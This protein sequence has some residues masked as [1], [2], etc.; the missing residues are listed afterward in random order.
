MTSQQPLAQRMGMVPAAEPHAEA[1]IGVDAIA[2]VLW[3][4]KWVLITTLAAFL[5]FGT[6]Y[7][8]VAQPIYVADALV[9]VE[10]DESSSLSS[11]ISSEMAKI[12]GV[13]SEA[14]VDAE[15]Q[16][17]KSRLV[18]GQVIDNRKMELKAEPSYFPIFGRALARRGWTG[19]SAPKV[20]E[21][22]DLVV[23]KSLLGV[24]FIVTK[25]EN[26]FSLREDGS[27]DVILQGKVGQRAV[28]SVPQ[29]EIQ[30]F[31]SVLE[32]KPGSKFEVKRVPWL[33]VISTLQQQ[34]QVTEKGSD[35]G[36]LSVTAEATDP[37]AAR[38]V[39]NQIVTI[40]QRQNVERKS[41]EAENQLKFVEEQ[42][43][44]VRK[45]LAVAE[46]A[47]N[48]FRLKNGSVDLTKETE[49]ALSS[50]VDLESKR[51]DLEQQLAQLRTK[52]TGGHPV[53]QTIQQQLA[54]IAVAQK[55]ISDDI[56]TL[57]STQQELLQ[58]SRDVQVNNGLYTSLLNSSQELQ[59]VKAGTVGNVRII[60]KAVA[61]ILAARP[62]VGLVVALSILLGGFVGIVIILLRS[63]M[64]PGVNDPAEVEQA[65][66]LATFASI[67]FS[68]S[69]T[70][71]LIGLRRNRNTKAQLLAQCDPSDQAIE[72]L[73]NL[74]AS[75]HFAMLDAPNNIIM[76]TGPAPG[77]GKSFV[78][79]NL[80]YVLATTGKRVLVIDADMRRGRLHTYLGSDRGVGLSDYLTG[81]ANLD[82]IAQRV[83][84]GETVLDL[85]TTGKLPPNPAELLLTEQL[86]NLLAQA[87]KIYDYV[88]VDTP[89]ILAVTDAAIVGRHAGCNLL[90]LK[91]A[92][93]PI[94]II[95]ES[96]DRLS[97]AGV[98]LRGVLF[99][100][101]G[102]GR[103][104]RYGYYGYGYGYGYSN[105]YTYKSSDK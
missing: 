73:R 54:Q 80:G 26:G 75:L 92:A 32:G 104:A 30:I 85:I 15:M 48:D 58:L 44:R 5:G 74:R 6:L 42:L 78:S 10:T 47:V 79:I 63:A 59:V 40:Y 100:Q 90:L 28:A 19:E 16:L 81:K 22:Q 86:G 52:F 8:M 39:V 51:L 23:P 9:Q 14:Q 57:P 93:H 64:N 41:A 29:G 60:D 94:R 72:S 55:R 66:G 43:P 99:N 38:D 53:I 45:Q 88:I 34:V 21:M 36:M 35:S 97:K 67:P 105:Y 1:G 17:L 65:L 83:G 20:I 11:A 70:K 33:Q 37:D 77:L 62:Q 3:F 2:R 101:V 56:K 87:G 50:S 76:L 103:S 61:P 27:N 98:N 49:L 102:A 24:E 96:C 31:L 18:L 84:G 71:L 4:E 91:A 82:A 12:T 69:Q 46:A 68:A 7:C 13:G 25:E 89:P 95:Q